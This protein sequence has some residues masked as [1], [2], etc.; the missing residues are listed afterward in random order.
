MKDQRYHSGEEVHLG[1]RVTFGGCP[2]TITFVIDR[3]EFPDSESPESRAWWRS[4]H[5]TGF[6][7]HQDDGADIFLDEADE[8]L[9][10]VSRSRG[11]QPVA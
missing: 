6:M 11:A 8:D 5:R 3:D 10:F 1:D 4:E 7:I 9:L 2:S